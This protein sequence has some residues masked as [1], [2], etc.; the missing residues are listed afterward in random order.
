MLLSLVVGMNM[1]CCMLQEFYDRMY[2]TD[3]GIKKFHIEVNKS[4][5]VDVSN[6]EDGRRVIEFTMPIALPDVLKSIVGEPS[7]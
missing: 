1:E 5:N 2:V 4:E 7:F 3:A 6:W